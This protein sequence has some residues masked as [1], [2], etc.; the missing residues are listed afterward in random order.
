MDFG[1]W[2]SSISLLPPR[3]ALYSIEPI[4]LGTGLVE[5]LTSYVMRLAKAHSVSTGDLIQRELATVPQVEALRTERE[6]GSTNS[7]GNCFR[8]WNYSVNGVSGQAA[9]WIYSLEAKTL[10]CDLKYLTLLP[11]RSFLSV[12]S[13]K[14]HRSWCP[15][16]FEEQRAQ[17]SHVYEPLLWSLQV[18]DFCPTHH[19]SLTSRCPGCGCSLHPLS[20]HARPGYCECCGSWLGADF[21]EGI[22]SLTSKFDESE[23]WS[24]KQVMDMLEI[25]P[26]TSPDKVLERFRKGLAI[27]LELMQYNTSYRCSAETRRIK[28]LLKNWIT[29][30]SD[31]GLNSLLRVS[32]FLHVPVSSFF[33]PNGPTSHDIAAA[34][35]SISDL[36][37]HLVAA[38]NIR[39]T[40]IASLDE[41]LPR[42]VAEIAEQLGYG[43]AGDLYRRNRAIYCKID[44]RYQ[45]FRIDLEGKANTGARMRD[46]TEIEN[47][48]KSSLASVQ[49]ESLMQLA[50]KLGYTNSG[51]L[52][53]KFPEL[54]SK[55]VEKR[56]A[57]NPRSPARIRLALE[58]ALYEDPPPTISILKGRLGYVSTQS[59]WRTYRNLCQQIE[60]RRKDFETRRVADICRNVAAALSETPV[61]S[62][63]DV[64]ER[65][66]IP[67]GFMDQ[68]LP[69]IRTMLAKEH[70]RSVSEQRARRLESWKIKVHK[71]VVDI[72]NDGIYPTEH[73][74][75]QRL[76]E[77]KTLNWV[78]FND[79]I[80]AARRSLGIAV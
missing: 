16:C 58:A 9:K 74:I 59:L 20:P 40:L 4:G 33:T 52:Q 64:C 1:V 46:D 72:H 8:H 2:P 78:I 48:L 18:S 22:G 38:K 47:I 60:Q 41:A 68:H 36:E 79:A 42:S 55:I 6:G 57:D 10:R 56:S 3:S 54:Y 71:A 76:P 15:L 51:S 70:R 31:V 13:F 17:Q 24:C 12:V 49:T 30:I 39:H 43:D 34:Q 61:P 28:P 5:G 45:R 11:L 69:E 26:P 29:G 77:C 14:V 27:Y 21:K 50:A 53:K 67:R 66:G 32:R 73:L 19:V 62:V 25:I 7:N 37:E 65:L 75:R 23:A 80:K 63:G 44:A 35:E